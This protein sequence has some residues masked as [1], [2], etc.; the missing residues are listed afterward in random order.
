MRRSQPIVIL[1]LITMAII[2]AAGS[3]LAMTYIQG[4]PD[5][6]QGTAVTTIEG[7]DVTVNGDPAKAVRVL[8]LE[9]APGDVQPQEPP[10]EP[11]AELDQAQQEPALT[12]TEAL[13]EPTQQPTATPAPEP[14]IF[15]QYLV[16]ES[17]TLYS[18]ARRLDTA[19][20]LMA[21]YGI[22]QDDLVPGNVISLPVGNPAFCPGA[23]Q[24]YAVGEGDTA[25]SVGRRFNITADDLRQLNG[26]DEN[27]TIYGASI[28]C[29]PR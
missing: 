29:V 23:L 26:L 15:E 19:I 7:F 11:S 16:Q 13:P 24:P 20:A 25:F 21:R 28:I 22:A 5:T 18:I 1:I 6:P 9:V 3:F 27:Y 14:I 10:S 2:L 4:R 12:P 17:E 8:N